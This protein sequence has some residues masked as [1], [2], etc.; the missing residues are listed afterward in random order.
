MKKKILLHSSLAPEPISKIAVEN[1]GCREGRNFGYK[2][3]F[4]GHRCKA[5]TP[6]SSSFS[7]SK[8]RP[9]S[10]P[11]FLRWVLGILSVFLLLSGVF[12]FPKISSAG[13]TGAG[14][15]VSAINF[16][17]GAG[18]TSENV[19][20][21]IA[22]PASTTSISVHCQTY[23]GLT[24]CST[25][26]AGP[27]D[28]SGNF[29]VNIPGLTTSTTYEYA[30]WSLVPG[31]PYAIPGADF[32]SSNTFTTGSGSTSS[33]TGPTITGFTID[34]PGCTTAHMSGTITGSFTA[35]LLLK[36]DTS[37][38]VKITVSGTSFSV[39]VTGLPTNGA[40][41]NF[42][43]TDSST[44]QPTLWSGSFLSASPTGGCAPGVADTVNSLTASS[45][46][47]TS[48]N[49]MGL[50]STYG[51]STSFSVTATPMI[52]SPVTGT[53]AVSHFPAFSVALTGLTAST[54]YTCVITSLPDNTVIADSATC[55]NFTTTTPQAPGTGNFSAALTGTSTSLAIS[56]NG[57]GIAKPNSDIT[58][59]IGTSTSAIGNIT[60]S[61]T[62]NTDGTFTFN[63]GSLLDPGTTYY[64]SISDNS[65][66][67][68]FA[69]S[70]VT[71]G[72]GTFKTGGSTSGGVT[73]S[74]T[75]FLP[76]SSSDGTS[77]SFTAVA[78]S[79]TAPFVFSFVCASSSTF[80]NPNIQTYTVSSGLP[81]ISGSVTLKTA[82][83][84]TTP[85][86][87]EI[88]D[89][90]SHPLTSA[91]IVSLASGQVGTPFV[92]SVTASSVTIGL[93]FATSTVVSSAPDIYYGASST[94]S[95]PYG[96][97][98]SATLPNN[99]TG[100]ITGLASSTSYVYSVMND[101]S[102]AIGGVAPGSPFG[103][104]KQPFKTAIAPPTVP[105]IS[106]TYPTV[107]NSKYLGGGIVTCLGGIVGG[108]QLCG[109]PQLMAMIQTIIGYLLFI[110]A[111]AIVAVYLVYAGW[112]YLSAGGNTEAVGKAKGMMTSVVT[113]WALALCAWI[114]V[115]FILTSLGYDSSIFPTFY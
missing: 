1:S 51:S 72:S 34:P 45:T 23:P 92:V 14:Q 82:I 49:I 63:I 43:V 19:I 53:L 102:S 67:L 30:V 96:M 47:P 99:Y 36:Y 66:D 37:S 86:Y 22:N 70:Q 93:N 17:A 35:P 95:A 29:S 81:N 85:A 107:D 4:L 52:G 100:T 11:L 44:A 31:A 90:S 114:I 32:S 98:S 48:E 76:K 61:T 112:L 25:S 2:M 13:G 65:T 79:S 115:K 24:P 42:T 103:M 97:S 50:I 40:S 113:G 69:G 57:G 91:K 105:S 73:I 9:F 41:H 8:F 101:G 54:N 38:S 15:S 16:T 26:G 6:S 60:T 111:P 62:V 89:S 74:S 7:I 20:G 55:P 110:V 46:S 84:A 33:S 106:G 80:T 77:I 3:S 108:Q 12:S 56:G 88:L 83:T 5:S 78:A 75:T 39:T 104:L 71:G 58:V 87:C 64:Y 109:F 94:T 18:G 21:T 28:S 27:L 59:R 68:A 10:K